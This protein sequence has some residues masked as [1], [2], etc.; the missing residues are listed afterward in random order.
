FSQY[1]AIAPVAGSYHTHEAFGELT[2][3]LIGPSMN[4]PLINSANLH[5]A[6]RYTDNSINGGFWSYT[7]GGDISPIPGLTVRG[8]YTRSFRQP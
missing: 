5:G 7:A 1:A 4:V 3:P 2:I 8:N 6:A